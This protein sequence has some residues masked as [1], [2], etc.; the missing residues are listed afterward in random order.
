MLIIAKTHRYSFSIPPPIALFGLHPPDPKPS[1]KAPRRGVVPGNGKPP[2]SS[3]SPPKVLPK[4]PEA[5]PRASFLRLSRIPVFYEPANP[6]TEEVRRASRAPNI[7]SLQTNEY[8]NEYSN[9]VFVVLSLA[10]AVLARPEAGYPAQEEPA[11]YSFEYEVKDEPSGNDFGHQEARDGAH[12]QGD[13]FVRLPD[14]RLQQV[15]YTVDGDSGFEAEVSY[16]GEAKH[17]Q[18][19]PT[20]YA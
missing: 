20:G 2:N 19:P 9:M 10:A 1:D 6:K 5:P 15:A 13:Y 7:S 16:E 14:G 12:T 11:K 8:P 4:P 18:H 17:P 3:S